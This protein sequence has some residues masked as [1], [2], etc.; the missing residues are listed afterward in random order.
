MPVSIGNEQYKIASAKYGIDLKEPIFSVF[1]KFSQD[2]KFNLLQSFMDDDYA[3][4]NTALNNYYE[5]YETCKTIRNIIDLISIINGR[6]A[7]FAKS[8]DSM[9]H[10][11]ENRLPIWINMLAKELMKAGT[12]NASD[13]VYTTEIIGNVDGANLKKAIFNIFEILKVDSPAPFEHPIIDGEAPFYIL[14]RDIAGVTV[15]GTDDGIGQYL[16]LVGYQVVIEIRDVLHSWT[17]MRCLLNVGDS[18]LY[19]GHSASYAFP[20]GTKHRFS[21]YEIKI[22]SK[23]LPDKVYATPHIQVHYTA[24]RDTATAN[25]ED[26]IYELYG[27][28][29]L[30]ARTMLY[31]GE[32]SAIIVPDRFDT[33]Y[34]EEIGM[35]TFSDT[36]VQ[37]IYI[38]D[39][40]TKIE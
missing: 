29:N 39:G 3:D 33:G 31:T 37:R 15:Y 32:D 26:Y 25:P 21:L 5:G 1:D 6:A 17:P 34:T 8:M 24:T 19:S 22:V 4:F 16:P 28:S 12:N 40:V 7:F 10:Y 14:G 9:G 13:G 11:D 38:P 36:K 35:F 27:Q 30:K 18:P 2:P 23:E 20:E